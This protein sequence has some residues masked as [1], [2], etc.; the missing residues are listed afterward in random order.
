MGEESAATPAGVAETP[1]ARTSV[2]V[3]LAVVALAAL[4]IRLAALPDATGTSWDS[5][6]YTCAAERLGDVFAGTY[7]SIHGARHPHIYPLGVP[8]VLR[9]LAPIFGGAV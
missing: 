3:A 9:L 4:L 2:R 1:P 7:P 5:P 6:G 8:L